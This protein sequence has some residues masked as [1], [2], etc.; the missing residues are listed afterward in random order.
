MVTRE[1]KK[2]KGPYGSRSFGRD[3]R[4]AREEGNMLRKKIRRKL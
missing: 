4:E 3:M 1:F 2:I